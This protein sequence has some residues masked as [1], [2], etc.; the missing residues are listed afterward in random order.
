MVNVVIKNP[1]GLHARP[2]AMF[3]SEAK[4]FE[5]DIVVKKNGETYNAKS[6]IMV[7]AASIDQHDEIT[8]V[9]DGS[10]ANEAEAALSQLLSDLE[11]M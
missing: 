5:C 1:T 9:A 11:N 10:D 6:P 2:A 4:K 7:M 8:I 3:C